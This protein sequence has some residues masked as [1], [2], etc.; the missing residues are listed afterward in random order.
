[1]TGLRMCCRNQYIFLP[2][3]CLSLSDFASGHALGTDTRGSVCRT[4]A[5]SEQPFPSS[6]APSSL[7]TN[8]FPFWVFTAPIA[9]GWV[10]GWQHWAV[11]REAEKGGVGEP[12][13]GWK[14][15]YVGPF[16]GERTFS[17]LGLPGVE[18]LGC[19]WPLSLSGS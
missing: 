17:F 15:C 4:S 9:E 2:P 12:R 8:R 11:C 16:E 1:M 10:G 6:L 13:S 7:S 14:H 18:Q 19:S 3:P 5:G